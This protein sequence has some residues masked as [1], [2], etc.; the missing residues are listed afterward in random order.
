MIKEV[1][2]EKILKAKEQAEKSDLI[3]DE[4]KDE[5]VVSF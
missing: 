2:K 3:H 1:L 5:G 4:E